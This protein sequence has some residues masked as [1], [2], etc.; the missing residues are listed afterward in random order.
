MSSPNVNNKAELAELFNLLT[1]ARSPTATSDAD[2]STTGAKRADKRLSQPVQPRAVERRPR[3]NTVASIL[4]QK[5]TNIDFAA[6]DYEVDSDG[7]TDMH[8]SDATSLADFARADAKKYPFAFKLPIYKLYDKA[9]WAK[10]VRDTLAR[11]KASFKPLAEQVVYAGAKEN[12]ATEA[13][14]GKDGGAVRFRV[15]ATGTP[16]G[17]AATRAHRGST[18]GSR[19]RSTSGV[20]SLGTTRPQSPAVARMAYP[21]SPAVHE[22][23]E[24]RALKRRCIAR[25]RS[26]TVLPDAE[27]PR[28]AWVYSAAVSASERPAAATFAA[29]PPAPPASPTGA[30]KSKSAVSKYG[31]MLGVKNVPSVQLQGAT[32]Q[33]RRVSEGGPPVP[34]MMSLGQVTEKNRL[35]A[36]RR[37]MALDLEDEGCEAIERKQ[38][39]LAF[40]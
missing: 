23:P 33:K 24:V 16:G 17:G 18:A 27:R 25:R 28:P 20:V 15:P 10:T 12:R 1:S 40:V 14:R 31:P 2:T 38:T 9:D 13:P 8:P 35:I 5:D 11:S 36:R 21:K 39:R 4:A 22:R 6:F 34:M 3:R 37:A 29:P 7:D 19:P 32:G 30:I 26:L